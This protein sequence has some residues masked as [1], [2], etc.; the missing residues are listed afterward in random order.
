M[1]RANV[2]RAILAASCIAVLFVVA[3]V[4][5]VH[6]SSAARRHRLAITATE[7]QRG[8]F[9]AWAQVLRW[10]PQLSK[11]ERIQM[12]VACQGW[13]QSNA[14]LHW[15][16]EKWPPLSAEKALVDGGLSWDRICPPAFYSVPLELVAI[17]E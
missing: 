17:E 1:G 10:W 12:H 3:T 11:A 15:K 6:G 2:V 4:S 8:S 16:D 9:F 13:R 5:A 7:A 14:T